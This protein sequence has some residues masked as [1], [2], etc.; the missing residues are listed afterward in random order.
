MT[1]VSTDNFHLGRFRRCCHGAATATG[2]ER[3]LTPTGDPDMWNKKVEECNTAHMSHIS[4]PTQQRP[5][6]IA[7]H[8][9]HSIANTSSTC[10][11]NVRLRA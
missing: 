11:V 8:H 10:P 4:Q 5:Q 6:T 3:N 2:G 1:A 9:T 7:V